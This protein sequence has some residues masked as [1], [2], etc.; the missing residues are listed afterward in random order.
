MSV[1]DY[2]INNVIKTYMK[3][4]KNRMTHLEKGN[5]GPSENDNVIISD[6]GMK[7]VLFERIGERMTERLRRHDQEG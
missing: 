7:R 6:E 4:M 3:N 1:F 2:Q 5:E